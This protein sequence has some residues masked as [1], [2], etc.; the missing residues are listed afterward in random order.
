MLPDLLILCYVCRTLFHFRYK[1]FVKC[2]IFLFLVILCIQD[3]L[4]ALAPHVRAR[5][6]TQRA[7]EKSIIDGISGFR[8]SRVQLVREHIQHLRDRYKALEKA[9]GRE[10]LDRYIVAN[11][12][13]KVTKAVDTLKSAVEQVGV[14]FTHTDPGHIH[15]DDL[16]SGS[17]VQRRNAVK[18]RRRFWMRV[19][20]AAGQGGQGAAGGGQGQGTAGQGV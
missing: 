10:D 4:S 20:D 19:L 13:K 1:Q 7:H 18:I 8:A 17:A 12:Q 14:S 15:Y 6:A 16:H 9:L 3:D 5:R 2:L 11:T